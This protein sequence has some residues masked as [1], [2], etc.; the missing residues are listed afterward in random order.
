M[1]EQQAPGAKIALVVGNSAYETVG[2]LANPKH[3]AAA[4]A[5]ALQGLGFEVISAI[6][7]GQAALNARLQEFYDKLDRGG[8]SL[9]FYAGH[10]VQ[11]WGQNFLLPCD[12]RIARAADLRAGAVP[13]NDVVRA[14]ARRA[15]TRL[16]FLDAC[17]NDPISGE[18]GGLARGA[19]AAPA[20]G[21]DIA[22]VGQ[23]LAKIT[24]T[25][26]TFVAYAT[27]PG[28]VALDGTG[29][30]SPFTTALLKHIGQPGLAVDDIMM[31]VRVDVLDATEGKQL[32]WSESALTQ[33]F[34]F[35]AGPAQSVARDF[36]QEYWD[37]VKDTD[38]PDFLDSFL[39]QFPNGQHAQEVRA[40]IHGVRA[41]KEAADWETAR[42]T[43]T[44]AAMADFARRYPGSERAGAARARLFLRQFTRGSMTFG[45][46]VIFILAICI[47]AFAYLMRLLAELMPQ[48]LANPSLGQN[49]NDPAIISMGLRLLGVSLAVFFGPWI[50]FGGLLWFTLTRLRGRFIW[51][52]T[53]SFLIT[54]VP[55]FTTIVTIGV[56][57]AY[58]RSANP[59]SDLAQ[60]SLKM[61]QV[62]QQLEA[63]KKAA[64]QDPAAADRV[65]QLEQE[66]AT[67]QQRQQ[68]VAWQWSFQQRFLP[69]GQA[70][71]AAAATFITLLLC[72]GAI[73][74]WHQRR[75][76]GPSI[77]GAT[78]T[79]A[80]IVLAW[81]IYSH[82]VWNDTTVGVLLAVW[83]SITGFLALGVVRA[84]AAA[85]PLP[86]TT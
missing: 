54:L 69:L 33:R 29:A 59:Q 42:A 60:A 3:D 74:G 11:V 51:R 79:A 10:G 26:G 16:L 47:P 20:I 77:R 12:I 24:A 17:R 30:N 8:T 52:T 48:Y 28:N 2:A 63:Q 85:E 15:K 37:R 81:S 58:R 40:R 22:D 64:A 23:G 55:I 68:S 39:R 34:Q 71:I 83:L 1:S 14:M 49:T 19:R 32:P 13:L 80:L 9:L 82:S 46:G 73:S 56:D 67:A 65:R 61:L 18:A 84:A 53:L 86:A 70:V 38:N 21:S 76:W 6:D 75:L 78:L 25:A 27:E 72:A 45:M 35:T 36:E 5:A 57:A 50:V 43:D 62:Q 31:E 4:M 41:R 66:F 44:I 7:V